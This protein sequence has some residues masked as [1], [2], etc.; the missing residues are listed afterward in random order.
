MAGKYRAAG[1]ASSVQVGKPSG[2]RS[3]GVRTF[4]GTPLTVDG[5]TR[6][7][8]GSTSLLG[9]SIPK[10]LLASGL[11]ASHGAAANDLTNSQ[12]NA[13][14]NVASALAQLEALGKSRALRAVARNAESAA[15]SSTPL[16]VESPRLLA[17]GRGPRV[18]VN[19]MVAGDVA[20]VVAMFARYGYTVN[21][22]F[23]PPRLDVMSKMSYWQCSDAVVL[24]AVP[25]ERR[26]TIAEAFNRGTTVWTSI[27]EIGT[28][29]TGSNTPVSGISY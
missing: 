22:A 23:T 27:A 2:R 8:M 26:Q 5:I 1:T 19:G 12:A 11:A 18:V 16:S 3:T 28:D 14:I 15:N 25:Q 17:H 7:A 20:R 13:Q 29:V 10:G 9:A 24:G 4:A 21:R 6:E